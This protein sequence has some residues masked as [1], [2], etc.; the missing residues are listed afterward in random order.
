MKLYFSL[1]VLLL[2]QTTARAQYVYQQ[3]DNSNG[4]SNSI[5]NRMFQD[6]DNLLWVATLDGLNVYDGST[7]HVFNYERP[8]ARNAIASNIIYQISEDKQKN[9]WLATAEGV[10]RYNKPTGSFTNYQLNSNSTVTNGYF[11]GLDSVGNVYTARINTGEVSY[12]DKKLNQFKRCFVEGLKDAR[13]IKMAIDKNGRL[14]L[15]KNNCLVVYQKKGNGFFKVPGFKAIKQVDN[16]LY[17]NHTIFYA[18]SANQLYKITDSLQ[19]Q[20]VT[21]LPDKV[22]SMT[23]L[24]NRYVF[25]W[26]L[27]GIGE[28][29]AQFNPVTDI[30]NWVPSLK[31]VRINNLIVGH[32]QMLW[33]GTDGEGI[34]KISKKTNYFNTAS[35]D[36]AS[37]NVPVNTF[38]NVN[39]EIWIGTKRNG[40]M[41]MKESG[42]KQAELL[43]LQTRYKDYNLGNNTI[44]SIRKGNDNLVYVGTDAAGVYLYDIAQKK[45][46]S[47]NS[48]KGSSAYPA[49]NAVHAILADIDGSVWLGTYTGGLYHLKLKR[50]VDK[51]LSV[52]YLTQYN[53]TGNNKGPGNDVINAL[54]AGANG[55]IWIACRFGGL[56]VFNK[57]TRLFRTFKASLQPGSL[58][59]NDVLSLYHDTRGQL[60]IGT[61]Y[62]LN[63]IKDDDNGQADVKFK[64]L[65]VED[66]LPSNTIHAVGEDAGS[67]IWISTNKGIAKIGAAKL[68]VMQ[69]KEQDGLQGNE[70]SDNA[71][72]RDQRN[73]LFFGGIRGFNYFIPQAIGITSN[74]TNLVLTDLKIAGHEE[75]PNATNILNIKKSAARQVPF[76]ELNRRD[77][78]FDLKVNTIQFS[79][80]EKCQYTYF[81]E[82]NDK[83]WHY[84]GDDKRISYSNLQPGKYTLKLRWSNGSGAWTGEVTAFRI[85]IKQYFWLTWPAFGLYMLLMSIGVYLV[86]LYRKNKL[87]NEHKL[88]MEHALRKKDEEVHR[89]QLDYFTNIAHELQTP[90]TIITGTMERYFYK[91]KNKFSEAQNDNLLFAVNEQASRLNYLVYQLLEFRKAEEGHLKNNYSKL[92]VSALLNNIAELFNPLAEQKN[93]DCSCYAEPNIR[94]WTDKDKLEKIIFNLLSNAIKH[95]GN[96]QHVVYSLNKA[97]DSNMLELI[98]ANSGCK[99]TDEEIQN[100]FTKFFVADASQQTKISTGLGLAFTRQLVTL[101]NGK[102]EVTCKD[103]WIRFKVSLPMY[104]VPGMH[105]R[106]DDQNEKMETPSYLLSSIISKNTTLTQNTSEKN[107]KQSLLKKL[108]GSDKKSILVIEDEPSIRYLL[109]DILK[110]SYIVYEAANGKD[111]L[112]LIDKII[113]DLIVSDIMMPDMTGLEICNRIKALQHTCHIPFLI[114]SAKGTIDQQIEGYE[115]GADAYIAKPFHIEHLLVRVKRLLEY[116]SRL[117]EFFSQSSVIDTLPTSGMKDDDKAFL[118]KTIALIEANFEREDLDAQFLEKE[119]GM[120]KAYF[121]RRLKSLSN[122]TPGELI[123]KLRLQHSAA[124]LQN[125][126]LTVAEIFY[127][128]GFNNQSHFFREFKKQY[129]QS[130]NDYRLQFKVAE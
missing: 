21:N 2:V 29:D 92:D 128:S 15:F 107:N 66:G 118:E 86:H 8:D 110:E 100:L 73:R 18:N 83:N 41:L 124:L 49:F 19:G 53:Y 5:V 63:V 12:Y 96:N 103:G 87:D 79:N 69:F 105:E 94:I 65:N 58:S 35:S 1:L 71:I 37:L 125:T 6:S 4:L 45:F 68:S 130:P 99:L 51:S 106:A 16:L 81:L 11:L 77:N 78:F 44:Y 112:E 25:A 40:I 129:N 26:G 39:G 82:G 84:V 34:I 119:L 50:G 42:D 95:T 97:E 91:I 117:H 76:Y 61:S 24:G 59:N 28:Y 27:K 115:A 101:L 111:A 70:F 52:E 43:P 108:E 55:N 120:S 13:I 74:Q 9:I 121:Y 98:V 7:F 122:M 38:C 127:R 46:I 20:L 75:G 116:H 57:Q 64:K 90:L 31:N 67:N 47:W 126:N 62:G 22:R 109:N 104:F 88:A 3:I 17:T 114:L 85:T 123:K 93:I 33:C 30:V 23:A 113:P 54:E 10:T 48:I 14:W 80:Q 36:K 56:S 89:D 102:I 32:E 60:W 72:W